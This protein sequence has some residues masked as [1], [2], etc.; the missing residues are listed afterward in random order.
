MRTIY[1]CGRVFTGETV[2]ENAF[3]DTE[4]GQITGVYPQLPADITAAHRV[5]WSAYA[6]AP[7]F[8]DLQIYGGNGHLF[9]SEPTA[10]TIRA[11]VEA[12]RAGGCFALQITL[13]CSPLE[14]MWR[15][16][17]ACRDYWQS[18]GEGLIGLHLEG[19]YFNPEKR[20]AHPLEHI[21]KP[22]ADEIK[23]LLER[24]RGVVSYIT[25]AP[26]QFE[27]TCLDLLLDSGI[28]V[29]AGHSNATFEQAVRAFDRGITRVTHLFNAMSA[30]QSRQPGLVGATYDRQP[31]ASIIA[32][33]IHC[34]YNA[35]KIS[36][37]ILGDKLWLITDAVTESTTGDYQFRFTGDRFVNTD[38]TLS[39]SA[40]TMWQ[41]VQN[42]VAHAGIPL[43]EAL[44]MASTYPAEVI[45]QG[46]RWGKIKAGYEA[47][48]VVMDL[49]NP[50]KCA[51][52]GFGC[53]LA[54]D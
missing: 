15:A 21:R 11:T 33:G 5:D 19:P 20:G 23:M 41:A 44:R 13:S 45:E 17:D 7:A 52:Q 9:N 29:A 50:Q 4:N 54:A 36:K 8:I 49:T 10:E 22:A 6:V 3:I 37:K 2:L 32:D 12:A 34:D 16:M 28:P 53:T 30:F 43:E 27:D 42:V 38:G 31:W 47:Q 46:H 48:M 35:L 25:V 26:E 39:G 51:L 14:I 40:L 24:G 18:G 1:Q